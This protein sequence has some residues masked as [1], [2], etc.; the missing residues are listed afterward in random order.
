MAIFQDIKY[1]YYDAE[2]KLLGESEAFFKGA[3]L[4]PTA[5]SAD[6]YISDKKVISKVPVKR[7]QN[8]NSN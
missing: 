8:E 2:G 6:K 3:E 7:L 5:V 4:Y 1:L